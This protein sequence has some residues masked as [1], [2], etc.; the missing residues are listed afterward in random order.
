MYLQSA[1]KF[2]PQRPYISLHDWWAHEAPLKSQSRYLSRLQFSEIGELFV[3][4]FGRENVCILPFETFVENKQAFFES[5]CQYLHLN[6]WNISQGGGDRII[7]R[8]IDNV[9]LLVHRVAEKFSHCTSSPKV[10]AGNDP[11][12]TQNANRETG[13][14]QV[15]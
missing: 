13:G 9:E 1:K 15:D 14:S 8:R 6:P 7:N 11:T 2:G 4:Y 12:P 5:L 10:S 3:S